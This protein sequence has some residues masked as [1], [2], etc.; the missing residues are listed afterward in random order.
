MLSFL[1]LC[2]P[3]SASAVFSPDPKG[4]Q[5]LTIKHKMMLQEFRIC[6]LSAHIIQRNGQNVK[7]GC[8]KSHSKRYGVTLKR[9][10]EKAEREKEGKGGRK[11]QSL[12]ILDSLTFHF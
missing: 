7:S 11:G 6:I 12:R 2:A 1:Y 4:T 3:L 9:W 8:T 5:M 10:G